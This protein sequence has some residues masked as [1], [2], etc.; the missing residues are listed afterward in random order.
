MIEYRERFTLAMKKPTV[1]CVMMQR[2]EVNALEPWLRYHGHLFGFNNL[3]VIDHGSDDPNVVATL[4]AYRA[5]DVQVLR[6][7]ATADYKRKG[8]FVTRVLKILDALNLYDILIPLD[9]DEFTVL[10]DHDGKYICAR[11]AILD[12]LAELKSKQATLEVKENL[13]NILG[14]PGKFWVLPYQK[15]FFSGG[16]CGAVDH[17]S[18]QDVSGQGR[19]TEATRIVYIHFHLKRKRCSM[20]L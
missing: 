6:L 18:H 5:K 7:P 11:D 13:I 9:C 2:N 12:Y 20:A 14:V 1:C 16:Q 10:C 8:E 19:A 3:C 4:S 15:V 17:G